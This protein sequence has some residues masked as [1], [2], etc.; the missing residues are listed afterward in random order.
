MLH[1]K[2][3]ENRATGSKVEDFSGFLPYMGK[4]AIWSCDQHYINTK[5]TKSLHTKIGKKVKWFLRKTSFNFDMKMT[6]GQS[7]EITLTVNTHMR[8]ST[9]LVVCIYI[10]SGH[11]LQ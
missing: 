10:C 6:L 5:I 8:L 9:H 7:K 2:V 4:E 3:N 1:T 11:R